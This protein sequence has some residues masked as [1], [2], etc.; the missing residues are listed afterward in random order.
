MT[1]Q[2]LLHLLSH[3]A[4]AQ[5]PQGPVAQPAPVAQEVQL[6]EALS[7]RPEGFGAGIQLGDLSGPSIV[8]RTLE[9]TIQGAVGWGFRGSSMQLCAD[10][11][12]NL[13]VI[14]SEQTPRVS[15]AV[16]SGSGIR[17]NMYSSGVSSWS[18]MGLRVPL[19]VAALPKHLRID[20]Y[21]QA[22]PTLQLYPYSALLVEINMGGRYYF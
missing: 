15:Y 8:H 1:I 16:Y 6:E 17:L 5:G 12:R 14:A 3:D 2:L 11:T 7:G 19:G 18:S 13:R 10:Y 22:S 9:G 4:S 20:G 21:L